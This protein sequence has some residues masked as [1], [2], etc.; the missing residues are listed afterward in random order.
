M[1]SRNDLPEDNMEEISGL[2]FKKT[3]EYIT[4]ATEELQ[5]NVWLKTCDDLEDW[6]FECFDNVRYQYFQGVLAY[7]LG[8]KYTYTKDPEKLEEWLKSIGH[9]AISLRKKI[10]EENKDV[11]VQAIAADAL[12]ER[13]T[14]DTY[15]KH[16][17][18]S[19]THRSYPQTNIV[20]RFFNYIINTNGFE[21][22][23]TEQL[24][25]TIQGKINRIK[26]LENI[27]RGLKIK[28]T[29]EDEE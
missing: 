16:W 29:L 18:F 10:Y 20:K 23:M 4:K 12:Y 6:M 14:F 2:L 8:T 11:I 22:Y 25:A 17:N 21:E 3:K 28:A 5:K 19:D 15:F 24:D 7:L 26:E 9:D 1:I 13:A 27:I